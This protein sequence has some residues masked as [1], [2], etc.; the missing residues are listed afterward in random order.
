[1]LYF[2]KIARVPLWGGEPMCQELVAAESTVIL[3]DRCSFCT[4]S[5]NNASAIGE[6]QILQGIRIKHS[7]CNKLLFSLYKTLFPIIIVDKLKGKE[8]LFSLKIATI[9]YVLNN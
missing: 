5:R 2:F 9:Y 3:S 1:M 7:S 6:R 8:L 4:M